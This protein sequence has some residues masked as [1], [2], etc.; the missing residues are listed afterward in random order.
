MISVVLTIGG[1]QYDISNYVIKDSIDTD[2]YLFNVDSFKSNT[3]K[4]NFSLSKNYPYLDEIYECD[5]DIGI[6]ISENGI[7]VFTGYLTDSYKLSITSN[8]MKNPDFDAE[9]PGIKLLKQNW[10]SSNGL[11]TNFAGTRICDKSNPSNSLV[12]IIASLS[13]AT[14]S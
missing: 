3:N 6:K 1:T 7:S 8:G 9:D 11:V 13:G 5:D 12:H 14:V 10:K 4:A 2:Q